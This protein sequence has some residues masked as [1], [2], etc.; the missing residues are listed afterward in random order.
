ML[1]SQPRKWLYIGLSGFCIKDKTSAP[2]IRQAAEDDED[3]GGGGD[4]DGAEAASLKMWR[5][6]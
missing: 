1:L 2:L 5:T 4:D 3:R 6:G